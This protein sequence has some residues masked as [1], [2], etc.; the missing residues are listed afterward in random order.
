MRQESIISYKKYLPQEPDDEEDAS[1]H[2][3][4]RIGEIFNLC[5]LRRNRIEP[6]IFNPRENGECELYARIRDDVEWGAQ[7]RRSL[8]QMWIE[9]SPLAYKSFRRKLQ[10]EFHQRWWEMYLTIGLRRLGMTVH[11]CRKDIGPDLLVEISG[12]RIWTEAVA[13]K[14]G[15]GKDRVPEPV[16]NGVQDF[17]KKECL[18]R[19]LQGVTEK[20]A[21][22]ADYSI[23][24][25]VSH[26]DACVIALSACDLNQF[27]SLLDFPQ[28][29]PLSILAGAG[30]L[31]ISSAC[32]PYSGRNEAIARN[33]GSKVDT[34]L[35][36]KDEFSI[37]SA[38]LYSH[39]DPLNAPDEPHRT[40][41]LFLNPNAEIMLPESF[42]ER[43]ST[44]RVKEKSG[45]K[46]IWENIDP[47]KL[48]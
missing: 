1:S 41:S 7:T 11:T 15:T 25:I 47:Y 4:K 24:R 23:K 42:Y 31:V 2:I 10:F 28:P 37:I 27:G 9:Y 3:D 6:S 36:E 14:I 12:M 34:T 35:F 30:N 44:W 18:L 17:P 38:V 13:P 16:V 33:S 8:E 48:K 26:D 5:L 21:R 39:V 40:L 46:T 19:L 20:R 32:D 29:A 45:D 22:M 43:M